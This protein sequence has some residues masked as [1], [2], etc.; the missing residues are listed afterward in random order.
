MNTQ[1]VEGFLRFLR[2][3]CTCRYDK[4]FRSYA[5]LN[6]AGLLEFCTQQIY[7]V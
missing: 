3:I 4:R 5:I 1:E 7:V 6:S 2:V